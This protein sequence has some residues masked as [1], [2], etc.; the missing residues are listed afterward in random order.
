MPILGIMASQISGHLWAPEG[1]YDSLATVNLASATSTITFAGIP[2]GYK[3]L[4]IRIYALGDTANSGLMRFNSDSGSNY[5][6]H[7]I[8]GNGTAVGANSGVSQTFMIGNGFGDGP[9]SSTIPFVT[10]VD[11]LDYA[12]TNKYKTG[13]ML[14]GQDKNGSGRI[15]LMSGVW[16]NTAAITTITIAPSSGNY[17]ANSSFALYGVR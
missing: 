6:W 17:T 13:R 15:A 3:H 5:A 11:I 1:A 14:D 9:N 16:M 2:T 4:Q 12:N 7:A 10:V 8:N